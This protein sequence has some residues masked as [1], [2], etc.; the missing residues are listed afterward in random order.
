MEIKSPRDLLSPDEQLADFHWSKILES[1]NSGDL[2]TAISWA[3]T[4]GAQGQQAADFIRGAASA[5]DFPLLDIGFAT[6]AGQGQLAAKEYPHVLSMSDL[7]SMPPPTWLVEDIIPD[8]GLGVLVGA[9]G[10]GKSLFALELA[11]AVARGRPLFGSRNVARSGWVLV[12]LAESIAS[13]GARCAAYNDYHELEPTEDFGAIIDGVK[14][15]SAKAIADLSLVVRREINFRQSYP[16]LII[17]DTVSAA[18]PGVDENNQAAITPLLA[19]LNRWVRYGITV[20]A[21]HHPSKSGAA[22]R[23]SSTIMDNVDWMIGIEVAG[24][25]RE[26][27]P[28]KMRDMEFEKPLAF[29]V[30]KHKGSILP[31]MCAGASATFMAFSDPGLMDALRDHAY[32]MPGAETRRPV[33]DLD[34]R[35]GLTIGDLLTTWCGTA[36]I[37][38]GDV[39]AYNVEYSRRRRVLIKLVNEMV[40]DGRLTADDKITARDHSAIIRQVA[41]DG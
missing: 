11:N 15:T 38:G 41:V 26:V 37:P 20:V 17:L 22:Y 13:W 14:F 5:T 2:S 28:H 31:M 29:E 23:G 36:P 30:I 3:L 21:L 12:L 40:A 10:S 25:R 19:E 18:I 32:Y 24:K 33:R 9:A 4:A 27:I 16:V 39:K 35:R 7:Q 1:I 6:S 8:R 34:I